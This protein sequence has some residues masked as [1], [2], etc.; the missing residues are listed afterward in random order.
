MI[1]FSCAVP[2]AANWAVERWNYIYSGGYGSK[3][4]IDVATKKE[5][6]EKLDITSVR[7]APDKKTVFL[8][9]PD[10]KPVMQMKVKFNLKAADGATVSQEIYSTV[11]KLATNQP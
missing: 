6:H 1:A 8:E 9:I 11:H 5:G 4:Y 7:I 2:I 10:M 3:E